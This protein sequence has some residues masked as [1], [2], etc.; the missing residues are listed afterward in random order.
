MKIELINE[1][2]PKR[3]STRYIIDKISQDDDA[4]NMIE[5]KK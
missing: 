3:G 5:A 1:G 4:I 2:I